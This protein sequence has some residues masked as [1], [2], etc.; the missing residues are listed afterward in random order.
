M[1]MAAY[2]DV[3]GFKTLSLMPSDSIDEIDLE[4]IDGQLAYWS[5]WIDSRLRKRYSV[6]FDADNTPEAVTGW[7][8]RLVT[9]RC[10]LRRGVDPTDQQ[11]DVI[12]QDADDAK[13]EIDEAANSETGLFDLPIRSDTTATGIAR[14]APQ[15]YSEASPYVW[16]DKQREA[17]TTED[18]NGSGTIG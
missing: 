4:W 12:R 8:A 1:T 3:D 6:P 11:F 9:V 17:A 10:F 2:L 5:R 18:R 16:G 14:G 15:V 7:L 13:A